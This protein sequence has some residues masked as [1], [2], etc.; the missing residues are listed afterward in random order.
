MVFGGSL[1]N[2]TLAGPFKVVGKDLRII[3]SKRPWR[4]MVFLNVAMRSQGSCIP[5][6]ES[7]WA[8]WT[9]KAM[10]DSDGR[11]KGGICPVD[12]IIHMVHS[13]HGILHFF[14]SSLH[15]V[16]FSL[17]MQYPSSDSAPGLVPFN[18]VLNTF[19]SW[20]LVSFSSMLLT[21]HVNF[22]S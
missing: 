18:I 14:H 9:W 10:D 4:C 21:L 11:N 13:S 5:S 8:F 15:L 12:E 17:Q 2:H 7:R 19:T 6:Y 1:L 3:S 20:V 22:S 16:H